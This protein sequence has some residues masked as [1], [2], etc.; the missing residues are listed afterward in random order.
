MDWRNS[1]NDSD[2]GNR[3][4]NSVSREVEKTI[5][6]TTARRWLHKL[7]FKYK[8]YRKGIYNDGHDRSDVKHY[9]DSVF[10]PRMASYEGQFIK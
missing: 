7:G 4:T 9:R 1:D 6:S 5:A 3:S 10:L 2:I 8:K